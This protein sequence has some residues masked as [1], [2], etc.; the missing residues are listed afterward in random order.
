MIEELT[1]G[2]GEI[3]IPQLLDTFSLSELTAQLHEDEGAVTSFLY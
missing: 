2:A 1:E 3:R